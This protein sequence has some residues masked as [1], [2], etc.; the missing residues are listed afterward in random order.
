MYLSI[1]LGSI[2]SSVVMNKIGEIKCMAIGALLNTPW[3]LSLAL[4][5]LRGD[6]EPGIEKPWYLR[7]FFISPFII[8]LSVLNGLG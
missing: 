4:C 5:G 6:Y 2:F 8:I 1:G 3:I 7:S